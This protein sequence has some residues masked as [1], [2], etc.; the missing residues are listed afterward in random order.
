MFTQKINLNIPGQ[1]ECAKLYCLRTLFTCTL[2]WLML[3]QI[4]HKSSFNIV[5]EELHLVLFSGTD[6]SQS[7]RILARNIRV[8]L[9]VN[10]LMW[11]YIK[12]YLM[13]IINIIIHKPFLGSCEV[14]HKIWAR[15]VQLFWPFFN[16][17]TK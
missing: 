6:I 16:R 11:I 15:S 10:S 9:I 7:T 3:T 5:M 14:Q 2:Q 17:Q 1:N 4:L 8:Q 13:E 12:N